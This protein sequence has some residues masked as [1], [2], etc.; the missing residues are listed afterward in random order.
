MTRCRTIQPKQKSQHEYLKDL[1][2]EELRGDQI[3]GILDSEHVY[4]LFGRVGEDLY[5]WPISFAD[6]HDAI[7]CLEADGVIEVDDGGDVLLLAA[8]RELGSVI[9]DAN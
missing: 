1:I 4:T 8:G 3:A 6:F 7:D 2:V 5:D 9:G